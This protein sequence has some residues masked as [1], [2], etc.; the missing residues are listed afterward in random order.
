M[1]ALPQKHSSVSFA[2]GVVGALVLLVGWYTANTGFQAAG[3]IFLLVG[4]VLFMADLAKRSGR[5]PR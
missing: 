3:G 4:L 5:E 1:I 2:I